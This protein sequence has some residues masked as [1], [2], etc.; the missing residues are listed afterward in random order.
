MAECSAGQRFREPMSEEQESSLL[1]SIVP[2][3]T[4]NNTKWAVKT[5]EDWQRSRADKTPQCFDTSS[6]VLDITKIR[7]LTTQL[8]DMNAETLNLWLTRFVQ[9]VGNSKGE[10]YP[11]RSLYLIICG[12]KRYLCDKSGL[13]PLSKEDK[14][15]VIIPVIHIRCHTCKTCL[16]KKEI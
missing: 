4:Q 16:I 6:V 2:K 3:N 10:R 5:F 8:E 15:L 12:I 9:E 7:D 1:K 14:R 11:P 13:D